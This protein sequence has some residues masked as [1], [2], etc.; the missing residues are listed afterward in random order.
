MCMVERERHEGTASERVGQ[1]ECKKVY[2]KFH[3]VV[4]NFPY[5]YVCV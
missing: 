1:C 2:R 5:E 3:T 4:L